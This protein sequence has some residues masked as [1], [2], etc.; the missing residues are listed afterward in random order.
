RTDD[1]HF[2]DAAD[3][4]IGEVDDGAAF[5]RDRQVAGGDVAFAGGDVFE[6]AVAPRRDQ[7]HLD[8]VRLLGMPLVYPF[9]E[10]A[11]ELDR[12]PVGLALVEKEERLARWYEN[13][14]RSA[15]EHGVEIA[16]T[17]LHAR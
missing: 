8:I 17:C 10:L 2:L 4:R 15:L 16:A 5:R 6:Q 12:Y 9:L 13:T 3:V 7:H 11:G 14:D 1:Q